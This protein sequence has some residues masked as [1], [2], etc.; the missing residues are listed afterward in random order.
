[1][2]TTILL[3]IW[4]IL[5][6][7]QHFDR[8]ELRSALLTRRSSLAYLLIF[9]EDGVRYVKRRSGCDLLFKHATVSGTLAGTGNT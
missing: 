8:M 9:R 1:M 7:V 4:K 3:P 2:L 5:F 6:P